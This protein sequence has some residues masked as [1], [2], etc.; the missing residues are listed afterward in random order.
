MIET[1]HYVLG[2]AFNKAKTKVILI[3]KNRPLWQKDKLNGIGG[4][5]EPKEK[6]F[7]AMI[8]EFLEET[9]VKTTIAQWH[10]FAEMKYADDPLGGPAVI[11]CFRC[12]DDCVDNCVTKEDEDVIHYY[13]SPENKIFELARTLPILI[14]MAANEKFHFSI[15]NL[16]Y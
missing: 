13:F 12:F 3:K 5:I 14:P 9:G 11:H 16:T 1:K 2:F 15:L 7:Q 6:R 10:L 4:K 8:R